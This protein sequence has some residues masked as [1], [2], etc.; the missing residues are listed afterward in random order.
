LRRSFITKDAATL[1]LAYKTYVI[2]I[3]DYCSQVWSP[4]HVTDI[5]RIE[6]VQ[7][8]FTKRLNG[9]YGLSYAERLTKSN[10]CSLELRRLRADLVL[11]YK[12]LHGLTNIFNVS[13]MFVLVGSATTRG[14]KMKLK[15]AKP[16]LDTKRFCFA[17]RTVKVWNRLKEETVCAT[18]VN[19]FKLHLLNENL[20]AHLSQNVDYP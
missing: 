3:L 5:A 20:S 7:R 14:H 1:L 16:R 15:A 9:Y 12:I 18:S 2:P 17:Y 8:L 13:S 6:S 11:C 19:Y 10:L 4:H